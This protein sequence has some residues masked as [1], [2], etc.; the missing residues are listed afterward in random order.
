MMFVQRLIVFGGGFAL[1]GFGSPTA[2]KWQCLQSALQDE[3]I[4]VFAPTESSMLYAPHRVDIS[5]GDE[6]ESQVQSTTSGDALALS[7]KPFDTCEDLVQSSSTISGDDLAFVK[8]FEMVSLVRN[9]AMFAP[10]QLNTS[11]W[12][13]ITQMFTDCDIKMTTSLSGTP[14]EQY[15]SNVDL[16]EL[17]LDPKGKDIKNE[18][19]KY[20]EESQNELIC[21]MTQT[22]SWDNM[23]HCDAFRSKRN[24]TEGQSSTCWEARYAELAEQ[25]YNIQYHTSVPAT[26]SDSIADPPT[27]FSSAVCNNGL[28]LLPFAILATL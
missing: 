13:N 2:A 14:K 8:L 18:V 15:Y 4:C 7:G 10:Q 22:G 5:F 23:G 19:L 11:V 3:N 12:A 1:G 25:T 24:L 26:C 16:L 9:Y 27:A 20:L 17:M 6:A 28:F 21:I